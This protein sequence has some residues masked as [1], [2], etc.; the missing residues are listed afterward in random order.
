M[1]PLG[2]NPPRHTTEE[3]QG[4]QTKRPLTRKTFEIRVEEGPLLQSCQGTKE[5]TKEGKEE[6]TWD[7]SH[8]KTHIRI[9][10][11][12]KQAVT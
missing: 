3:P 8:S 5:G 4:L 6:V 9:S 7:P 2:N 11:Y 1:T 10:Q 12:G